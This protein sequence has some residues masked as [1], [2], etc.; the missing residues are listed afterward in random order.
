MATVR[1]AVT[2]L[3]TDRKCRQSFGFFRQPRDPL[4]SLLECLFRCK[5]QLALI[6][7][8][9]SELCSDCQPQGPV[10]WPGHDLATQVELLVPYLELNN[11]CSRK[12]NI[13]LRS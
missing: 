13:N 12:D 5:G 2:Y 3:R 10:V 1:E 11:V 6:V 8:T 7:V 4:V 9:C